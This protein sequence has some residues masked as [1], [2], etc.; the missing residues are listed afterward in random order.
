MAAGVVVMVGAY[1]RTL[2]TERDRLRSC[3]TGMYGQACPSCL[4][5]EWHRPR[6]SWP[7]VHMKP[8][9]YT[10]AMVRC[11]GVTEN[12]QPVQGKGIQ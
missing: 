3:G 4:H 2:E 6:R 8:S 7:C 12:F 5:R 1:Q 11:F 9:P 10:S